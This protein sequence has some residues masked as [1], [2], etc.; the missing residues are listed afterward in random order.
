[1]KSNDNFF[2]RFL[3]GLC[4]ILKS[5]KIILDHICFK[6]HKACCSI[7]K[8]EVPICSIKYA[9][10]NEVK[11]TPK[12]YRSYFLGMI[13][14]IAILL[15]VGN[16]TPFFSPINIFLGCLA[17]YI[18]FF[19]FITITSKLGD[20]IQNGKRSFYGCISLNLFREF[21]NSEIKEKH[22]ILYEVFGF[23][24]LN[25]IFFSL[26]YYNMYKWDRWFSFFDFVNCR[27]L[28]TYLDFL[29]FSFITGST[30]GYGDIVPRKWYI[31]IFV[32]FQLI[33][34]WTTISVFIAS[35]IS[36]LRERS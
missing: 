27:K 34:T 17:I 36:T 16:Y 26:Y 3:C 9:S 31:Q 7:R 14:F 10:C 6:I 5:L 25:Q 11:E 15:I 13:V 28:L 29:H 19:Y 1:M 4:F 24:F 21:I 8:K 22:S 18:P 20:V 30:L 35:V 23:F 33:I 12:N 2:N 32:I